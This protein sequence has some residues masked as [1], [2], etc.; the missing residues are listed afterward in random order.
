MSRLFPDDLRI[1]FSPD[2]VMIEHR[3]KELTLTGVKEK[4]V[5]R[6]VL[7]TGGE[8]GQVA[9]EGSL[10]SLATALE[11]QIEQRCTVT[12][13]L[14]N[15]LVRYALVPYTGHL[16]SEQEALVVRHCFSEI[17]GEAAEP[18]EM[19]VSPPE[20][21]SL[22]PASAVDRT[23]L[24]QLHGL[25]VPTRFRLRS[26][27]PRLMFTCNEHHSALGKGFAWLLLVEPGNLCIGLL[28][29]GRLTHLR[30]LRIGSEWAAELPWL[31]DREACLAEL[32]ESPVDVFL[33]NREG[34]GRAPDA[35]DFRRVHL[36]AGPLSHDPVPSGEALA[37]A[38]G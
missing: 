22:Q 26:I 15:S 7:A 9:W 37:I 38:R 3:T 16:P 2:Q 4:V 25:F 11:V 8:A 32:E 33:W 21:M 10:R 17:F 23:L 27:Q 34:T 24:E 12:V 18:W 30:G 14:A 1:D 20:G 35:I 6:Q 28:N 19:R 31:L 36:L 5:D 13:I 29:G